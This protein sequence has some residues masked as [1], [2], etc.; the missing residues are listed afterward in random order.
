METIADEGDPHS[1]A[2]D[3]GGADGFVHLEASG[4]G[5]VLDCRG[6]RLPRVL[7]WG[8]ALPHA[9]DADL[10]ALALA[11]LPATVPN[12]LDT[13][14]SVTMVPEPAT[15]WFGLPGLLG[16]R[17]GRHWSPL[18][19]TEHVAVHDRGAE[20]GEVVVL[21]SDAVCGLSLEL[22]LDLTA[23]GVL[24]MRAVLR[25][26][27]SGWY[28]LDGLVMALPVP[29]EAT[30]LLDF[31]G[32]WSRER[33]PQRRAFSA[34]AHVRDGR[35]GRTGSDASF[36]L[37]A[38]EKGFGFRSGQVWGVHVGWSG[39]H[40]TYA[41]RLPTGESVIGGG[42]L[43]RSGE[44]RLAPGASYETPWVYAVHGDGL[45]E[46]AARF[47]RQVRSGHAG[48]RP[49]IVNTWEAVYFDHD[50]GRLKAL[51]DAAAE[52]GA[53]RFVLDDGWFRGRRD[54]RAGLGDWYVDEVRWPEG[55]HPL[56][57]HVRARGMDF[58]LWVE[59][60]M[61]NPDSDLA[62][63]HPDWI[64][65]A[66]GRRPPPIR[67]QQAL[68]LRRPEAYQYILERLDAL[69]SEYR[70]AFLKWDHNRDLIDA[71]VHGQTTAVYRLMDELRARHPGLEIESC[72]SGGARV[73]LGILARTDRVW[74][75][76]CIDGLE[77]QAI[78]RWTALLLPPE[79]IGSHVGAA[80]SHTTGRTQSLALR[81]GTALF[82]HFGI[83]WDL[84]TATDE[85]RTELR[86]WVELYKRMRGWLHRGVVVRA[87]HPDPALWV[88]GI[89]SAER[90]QA[91]FSV[92]AM[93]TGA[94]TQ[95]GRVR[96]PGLD[97]HRRYHVHPL[98][99][100]D[101][102]GT[103][104]LTPNPWLAEGVVVTGEVLAEVGLSAPPL[105]PEQLLLLHIT[106]A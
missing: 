76:D 21:A 47:H 59:P 77:R 23:S 55:L 92:V 3:R 14:A 106:K 1:G 32:R 39:N 2:S 11:S 7:H 20:G 44:V 85:E 51:V 81:A 36:I 91:L 4:V 56:V 40:R 62:R 61:V 96:I 86:R 38:G 58:G 31:T 82:G 45:D 88:H 12:S 30:E 16:H 89:V 13:P 6:A 104:A 98:A 84:T 90:D 70:I 102:P 19:A 66:M 8:R 93:T 27:A 63:A 73:D 97:P 94:R 83:E 79:L 46:M 29:S 26:T 43:L 103:T 72:S 69:V 35:R 80:R 15:G 41:E 101:K 42:E 52:V 28:T 60:E 37:V 33:T 48:P 54:D 65:G 53:E 68:D 71:D 74:A 57:E 99:P 100:G 34:A 25:N 10:T 64:V 17:D 50:L 78:Q 18:F 95:P 24:R 105:H 75:S 9:T 5:L 67:H 87:D 49:V 22:R